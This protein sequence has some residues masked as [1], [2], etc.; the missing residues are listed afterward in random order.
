[1]LLRE[2]NAAQSL[3]YLVVVVTNQ[4]GIARGHFPK[5]AFLELTEWILDRFGKQG[6]FISRVYYCP[7]HREVGVG[8][9][10]RETPIRKP[11]PAMLIRAA[12]DF[13]LDLAASILIGDELLDMAAAESVGVGTKILFRS[14]T[15]IKVP[16]GFDYIAD[17]LDEIRSRFF[18]FCLCRSRMS[19][20]RS[21]QTWS[22][23]EKH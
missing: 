22:A 23:A 7:Y 14:R 10:K 4:S 17:F 13:D 16:R 21:A 18:T 6:V 20:Q 3:R 1:M 9:Y 15:D 19:R 2:V 11:Q 5:S 8:K 12:E